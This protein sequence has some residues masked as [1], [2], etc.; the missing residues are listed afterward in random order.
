MF[1]TTAS[2]KLQTATMGDTKHNYLRF[3]LHSSP[4]RK[5]SHNKSRSHILMKLEKPN[6]KTHI[7][8]LIIAL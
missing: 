8:H 7:I 1:L 2:M 3:S 5:E 6:E 4:K